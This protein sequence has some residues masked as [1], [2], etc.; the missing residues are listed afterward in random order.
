MI[1]SFVNRTIEILDQDEG[2]MGASIADDLYGTGFDRAGI[3]A[4]GDG[5]GGYVRDRAGELLNQLDALA[6]A[7]A[8]I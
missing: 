6:D 8:T 3:I 5:L 2:N 7:L 1:E 4:Q